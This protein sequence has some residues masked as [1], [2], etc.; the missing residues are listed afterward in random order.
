MH[1][2]HLAN[3]QPRLTRD[4]LAALA[5]RHPRLAFTLAPVN[6]DRD[7]VREHAELHDDVDAHHAPAECHGLIAPINWAKVLE[8]WGITEDEYHALV[9]LRCGPKAAHDLRCA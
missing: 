3:V 5:R 7:D 4:V 8:P 2:V 6:R 9:E 1:N